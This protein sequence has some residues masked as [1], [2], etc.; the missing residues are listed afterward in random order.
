MDILS[1]NN[2]T[3]EREDRAILTNYEDKHSF[4]MTVTYF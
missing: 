4:R 2:R 3:P 1:S